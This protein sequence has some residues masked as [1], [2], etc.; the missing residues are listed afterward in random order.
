MGPIPLFSRYVIASF[1]LHAS[2]SRRRRNN[3]SVRIISRVWADCDIVT[4][5]DDKEPRLS[6]IAAPIHPPDGI[7]LVRLYV[8]RA[9]Y[10]LI[11]IGLGTQIWPDILIPQDTLAA[12]HLCLLDRGARVHRDALA[13]CV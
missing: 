6:T 11:V 3:R 12:Q 13:F 4:R 9:L 1:P 8:L 10:L 7:S 2:A 5:A